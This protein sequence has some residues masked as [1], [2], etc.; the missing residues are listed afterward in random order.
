LI[1][2]AVVQAL[3]HGQ[4]TRP[5]LDEAG[6]P[7]DELRPFLAGHRAPDVLLGAAGGTDGSLDVGGPGHADLGQHLLRGRA[8]GLEVA[9][10]DGIYELAVDEQP[11][12]GP[13][14]HDGPGL[15][16]RGVWETGRGH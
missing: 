1:G 14:V 11:V 4:L 9:A 2:F 12:R 7:E 8:L 6:Y 5:F 10:V 15:R 13:Q 16:G 3:Q